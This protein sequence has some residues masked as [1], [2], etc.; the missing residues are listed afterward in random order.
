MFRS[1]SGIPRRTLKDEKEGKF[2]RT[3]NS[4]FLL[5]LLRQNVVAMGNFFSLPFFHDFGYSINIHIESQALAAFRF[6]FG[7]AFTS[8][9]THIHGPLEAIR[10]TPSICFPPIIALCSGFRRVAIG[11]GAGEMN[12]GMIEDHRAGDSSLKYSFV[13]LCNSSNPSMCFLFPRLLLLTLK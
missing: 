11:P 10:Q 3:I 9:N 13:I 8:F 7:A 12:R 4:P 5:S 2:R 6:A 1:F